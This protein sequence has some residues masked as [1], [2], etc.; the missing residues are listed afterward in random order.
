M[1]QG[2]IRENLDPFDE[3]DDEAVKTA[4]KEAGLFNFI[5]ETCGDGIETVIGETN[6]LFSAGQKQLMCLARAVIRKPKILVL[7][8]ASANID[9]ETD[10]LIQQ[11][12]EKSF[13]DCTVLTIAHRLATVINSD[14]VL[15]MDGGKA[16]E[17]DHPFRLLVNSLSDREITKTNAEGAPSYFA[18]MVRATGEETSKQLFQIARVSFKNNNAAQGPQKIR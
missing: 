8:E 10:N 1:I 7:D 12:L 6:N 3:F 17:F 18:S 4:L 11:Q 2:T 9:L 16:V 13:K 14:K 5:S 15:V